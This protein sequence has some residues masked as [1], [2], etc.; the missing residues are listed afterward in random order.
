MQ[1]QTPSQV[2]T[3]QLTSLRG[4]RSNGQIGQDQG[5]SDC[6]PHP[7]ATDHRTPRGGSSQASLD[8]KGQL[9]ELVW[10]LLL[11]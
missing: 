6:S 3:L 8:V 1:A 4:S 9:L 5:C 11:S 10:W 2:L 7:G